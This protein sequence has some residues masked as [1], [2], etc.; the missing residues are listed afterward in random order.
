MQHASHIHTGASSSEIHQADFT[1][2]RP[3]S[4][5]TSVIVRRDCSAMPD[6]N[7]E[8]RQP[9]RQSRRSRLADVARILSVSG[10]SSVTVEML[11]VDVADACRR[12]PGGTTTL[13]SIT[14]APSATLRRVTRCDSPA[15][16]CH[17][18]APSGGAN[19]DSDPPTRLYW[20]V[21]RKAHFRRLSSAL[22]SEMAIS[23][24][25]W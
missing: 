7:P 24:F 23:E 5:N 12:I 11:Q 10:P 16:A 20:R 9:G 4:C 14:S 19:G 15:A 2:G 13:S 8:R 3:D 21:C 22:N 18:S 17:A 25:D 6:N 1:Q